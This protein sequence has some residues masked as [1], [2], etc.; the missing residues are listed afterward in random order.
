ML[1]IWFDQ[2]TPELELFKAVSLQELCHCATRQQVQFVRPKNG[3]GWSETKKKW[4]KLLEDCNEPGLVASW[5]FMSSPQILNSETKPPGSV[6]INELVETKDVGKMY[7]AL[8]PLILNSEDQV[9]KNVET[10]NEK[11]GHWVHLDTRV[12]IWDRYILKFG[13]D[14]LLDPNSEPPEQMK[15]YL[16]LILS[17]LSDPDN[18]RVPSDVDI[19]TKC[20][21]KREYTS[22]LKT[23]MLLALETAQEED[24]SGSL[25]YDEDFEYAEYFDIRKDTER[26]EERREAYLSKKWK[27]WMNSDMEYNITRLLRK[28]FDSIKEVLPEYQNTSFR[29]WDCTKLQYTETLHDRFIVVGRSQQI[30]SAGFNLDE[31]G[32]KWKGIGRPKNDIQIQQTYISSVKVNLKIPS[33][34]TPIPIPV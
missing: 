32:S 22:H 11:L 13:I 12:T 3:F 31:I 16:I 20:A 26:A 4:K 10:L 30:S 5:A 24:E 29:I 19:V 33:K 23:Q 7:A 17:A 2:N 28:L 15:R 8:L 9:V 18:S 21:F 6:R 34:A 25:V 1:Q 14:K 27:E